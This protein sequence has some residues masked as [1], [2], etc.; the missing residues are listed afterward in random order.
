M[1][2]IKTLLF[3]ILFLTFA[4][5][6]QAQSLDEILMHFSENEMEV[7]MDVREKMIENKGNTIPNYSNYKLLVY[8]KRAPFLQIRTPL[9]V[10]YEIAVWRTEKHA[11]PIVALSETRCGNS[12]G[13]KITFYN[14]EDNWNQIP[15]EEF[16]PEIT[17]SDIFNSKRLEKNY[18][19]IETLLKNFDFKVQYLLP[20]NGH[21]IIV[22]FTCLDELDKK[23]YQRIFKYLDGTMLDLIWKKGCF[24]KSDP[25]F[26]A[27]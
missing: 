19:T 17:L 7:P 27:N 23:E 10:T 15:T 4:H 9:D 3:L 1:R 20:Q 6:L 11:A 14:P 18:L 22:L 25:Y 12:C 13:S 8:D 21:D 16:L 2:Q 5:G 24:I 26:P